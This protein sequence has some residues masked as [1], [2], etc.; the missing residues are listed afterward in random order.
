[1]RAMRISG[2]NDVGIEFLQ[3]FLTRLFEIHPQIPQNLAADPAAFLQYSKQNVFGADI[4]MIQRFG[5]F[6]CQ[7]QDFFSRGV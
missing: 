5:L 7:R 1:M 4:G 6:G 3:D 2:E